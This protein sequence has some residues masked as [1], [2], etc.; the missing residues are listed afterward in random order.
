MQNL[1]HDLRY[2]LRQLRKTPGMALLAILT[3]ALG[4][5][6]NTAIFTVIESVLLRPLPY[7]HSGRLVY[8]GGA[9]DQP[10]FSGTSW[11][12]YQDIKAQSR[13]LDDVAGYSEDISVLQTKDSSL[14]VAAPRVTSNLFSFLGVQPLL[15]RTFAENEGEPGGPLV[16]LLSEGLWRQDFHSDAGIVGQKVDIGAKPYTVIGVMPL[17]F[18][19]PES[20]GSDLQKGLWV[21]L[22]PTPEML[23][24]RG[25]NFFNVIGELK[26]GVTTAQVQHELDAIAAHIPRKKDEGAIKLSASSYQGL[27]TGPVRPVLYALFGA[28]ALVLLI[29]C[30]NVSNLLIARCLGRQQE[31]AVRTALGAGRMRLIRQMLAEGFALSLIGCGIGLLLARLAM[32]ALHK[33]PDGTIPRADAISIHWTIVLALATIAMVTT[34]LSSLLPALLVA[35]ANPQ[36]ALQAATRGVGSRSIGGKLSGGLVAAEV[37]FSTLLLVGT[38]LLFHTLWNLEQSRLGFETAHVTTFTAMPADAAGFSGLAVSEDTANA[39]ASIA[40][41]IYQPVLDRI[42]D[43]PGVQ[44]AA[45]ASSPPLSGMDLGSSFDILGQAKDPNHTPAARVSA[46]SGDYASTLGTPIIKGRMITDEDVAGSPFVVVINQALAHEYFS[47]KDPLG[48]QINLGGKDTG[49]IM[50]YTI[51]G[52]LADQVDKSVGGEVQ[53]FILIPQE[54]IPTTSLFYQALLKT[55]VSFVIKTRSDIPVASEM[56]SVFHQAAPSLALDNFQTMQQAVEQNTFGQRLGLY[57]VASFAGLAIAMVIA[58]LYGVLSQLVGYRRRE[59]GVR[60]ALGATR[61]S[62]AQMVLRQG[63]ILIGIGLGLGLVLA[64]ASERLV[65]SF[66][67]HVRPLDVWTYVSVLLI[68]P[69]IGLVAALLPARKAASIQPMQALRED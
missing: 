51:V 48:R 67:Y 52:V 34:V 41:L 64:V 63:S 54:Q 53:P 49:M 7:A 43:V 25:Y 68:L 50:P 33:L 32:V 1:L 24:D 58:G 61:Q 5:G 62:V 42:R 15:G 2:A 35:R 27:L 19:F 16:A 30:A 17:G 26:P 3:L 8:I 39:P 20:M 29:A 40:T 66:L 46:V 21:P 18:R 55:V 47:G 60:M 36:G 44:S 10:A 31:F 69:G 37:A 11:L 65:Q 13:L 59:I 12:N 23:K 57:L 14:S 28:L 6:A 4:I 56:R 38:G 22:Q 9:T 45:L